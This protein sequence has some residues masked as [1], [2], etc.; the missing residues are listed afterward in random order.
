MKIQR[1]IPPAAAPI[2]LTDIAHGIAGLF[3]G[4]RYLSKLED[5][6]KEYFGVKHVFL[7][8]SG[9]AGLTLILE[10]LKTLYPDRNQV[11]IPAY[12][13]FSVPSAIVKAGL[14]VAPCDI[15][16]STLDYNYDLL[17][18]SLNDRT[19]CVVATHLFGMP[20]D[21]DK[22]QKICKDRD[23]PLVEDAAQAMGG[24]YGDS[25]LGTLGDVG[26][27]SL[28]RGKNIT[29]G[30]GGIIVTSND[31]IADAIGSIYATVDRPGF[32]KE[33]IELCKV[34]AMACFIYPCLYWLPAG[35]P[36]LK[37]GETFFY[38]DFPVRGFSGMQAGLLRRWEKQLEES[39]RI[40]IENSKYF[41]SALVSTPISTFDSDR[42]IPFLRYPVV[43]S[44]GRATD[45]ICTLS[46]RD[47]LGMVRLYPTAINEIREIKDGLAGDDC[48]VA[49]S[50]AEMLFTIP[51]HGLLKDNDKSRIAALIKRTLSA[52]SAGGGEVDPEGLSRNLAF[53]ADPITKQCGK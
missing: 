28:G 35:L 31:A 10:A 40:R 7:V 20:S 39:N 47:G 33:M 4:R 27:F 13:C 51:T 24:K 26:F 6:L 45:N 12:T 22:M 21:M 44:C 43:C 50:I 34:I 1:T 19:L 53:V 29:C 17:E 5:E 18:R 36:F 49:Q 2:G 3:V 9:K 41:C 38:K 42:S 14:E 37:L 32:V 8:S 16:P 15:D 48:T 52:G 23:I 46:K 30:S 11:L 25:F